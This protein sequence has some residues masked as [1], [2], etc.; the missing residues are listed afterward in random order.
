MADILSNSES[1]RVLSAAFFVLISY[2]TISTMHQPEDTV[3][4]PDSLNDFVSKVAR[5]LSLTGSTNKHQGSTPTATL[6]PQ[7]HKLSEI[8][9]DV[10]WTIDSELEDASVE[11]ARAPPS[12]GSA[13]MSALQTRASAANEQR[14]AD[15]A[16]LV[17]L[18]RRLLVRLALILIRPIT[19]GVE[20]WSSRCRPLPR[21]P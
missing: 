8:I 6:S 20:D 13:T 10:L 2:V 18:I 17:E 15:R 5:S 12:A 14:M 4:T 19:D 3:I 1:V 9:V 7:A 11:E 16:K 21:T